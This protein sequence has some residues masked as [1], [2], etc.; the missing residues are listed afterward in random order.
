VCGNCKRNFDAS[1][2]YKDEEYECPN[3]ASTDTRKVEYTK[4]DKNVIELK[5][6]G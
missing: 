3:C 2:I 5:K 1:V 4:K 6:T